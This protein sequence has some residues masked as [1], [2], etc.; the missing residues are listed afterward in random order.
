MFTITKFILG[1]FVLVCGIVVPPA[2]YAQTCVDA[3]G[4]GFADLACGGTDC[5]DA[6]GAVHPGVVEVC[7]GLDTNC[8]G[9]QSSTD[10]DRDGDGFA[11]CN[12]D[13]DDGDPNRFPGN[14]EV[15]NGVDDDCNGV[16]PVVEQDLDHDGYLFCAVPSDC[17]DTDPAV[18]PG[19]VEVC[20]DRKDNDCNGRVDEVGCTCPDRDGDGYLDSVCEIGR[21]HV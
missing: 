7:D 18:Y 15:C 12:G 3:D 11:A 10:W 17:V 20:G 1:S 13:C 2:S 16:I 8:D 9:V 21:A 6:N 14:P 5:N 19:S 4:D